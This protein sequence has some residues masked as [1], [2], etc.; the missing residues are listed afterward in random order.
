MIF[1]FFFNLKTVDTGATLLVKVMRIYY[2][3]TR[4]V[5]DI[6]QEEIILSR[7]LFYLFM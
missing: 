4:I 3:H 7:D 6:S 2:D 1:F 5:K